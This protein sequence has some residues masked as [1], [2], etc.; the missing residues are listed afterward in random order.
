MPA[1]ASRVSAG[2]GV[3]AG[4]ARAFP[5]VQKLDLTH[6]F[7]SVQGCMRY[8][9]HA[10]LLDVTG[11]EPLN[12]RYCAQIGLERLRGAARAVSCLGE[13]PDQRFTRGVLIPTYLE[14]IQADQPVVHR[15]AGVVN[16]TFLHYRKITFPL[17]ATS[18]AAQ[19]SHLLTLTQIDLAIPPCDLDGV[20]Q[21]TP[22]ERQC[23]SLVASGLMTKQIAAEI[24]ISEKTVEFHLTHARRKLGARTTA[25]AVAKHVAAAVMEGTSASG[26]KNY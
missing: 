8:A 11:V 1:H 7:E 15:V 21:L 23:L 14:A 18:R 22:R 17:R 5:V 12:W 10:F 4:S 19:A 9:D 3:D 24:G 6:P 16:G 26:I 20:S 25:Q 2:H 13:Q